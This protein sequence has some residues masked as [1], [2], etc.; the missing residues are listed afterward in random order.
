MVGD[1]IY[2]VCGGGAESKVSCL[3]LL[4]LISLRSPRT[5]KDLNNLK[6]SIPY[7]IYHIPYT[8]YFISDDLDEV[9]VLFAALD[10]D[11][12]VV[13]QHVGRDGSVSIGDLL[14][15]DGDSAAL[16]HLAHLAL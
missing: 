8:L 10:E 3:Y 9:I 11:V 13:E 14:L 5:V 7:T 2:S 1:A 15:V 12:L 6:V 4:L 16:Y